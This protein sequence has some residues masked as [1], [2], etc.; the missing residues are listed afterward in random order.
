MI[1][2][3]AYH[4][5]VYKKRNYYMVDRSACGIAVYDNDRSIRSGTGMTRNYAKKQNLPINLIHPD[6]A[7]VMEL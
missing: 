3:R 2:C 1:V 7:T 5:D 6:R 4:P